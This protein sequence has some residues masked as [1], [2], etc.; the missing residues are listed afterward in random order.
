MNNTRVILFFA[1]A[2]LQIV[3]H[4]KDKMNCRIQY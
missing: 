4:D 2:L 1:I 3:Q